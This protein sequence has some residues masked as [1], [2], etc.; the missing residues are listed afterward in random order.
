MIKR[1]LH[2][3]FTPAVLAGRKFTTIRD[4]PWPVG[5]PIMLYNWSGAAYRS[6]QTDVAAITVQG[7]WPITISQ[8]PDGT[9]SYE[10]GMKNAKEL[11]ETEGFATRAEL[12]GWF[13][14]LVKPDHT[15]K[16]YLHRFRLVEKMNALEFK[17]AVA[18]AARS[19]APLPV[20]DPFDWCV[21]NVVFK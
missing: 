20:E 3:R 5:K 21:K 18:L 9:M 7:W 16:K 6:K 19:L 8:R 17:K 14:P 11:H 2:P 15:V 1:P 10:Y 12:D 4:K 13:R